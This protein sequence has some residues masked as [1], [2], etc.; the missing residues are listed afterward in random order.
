MGIL[1]EEGAEDRRLGGSLGLRVVE[2]VDESRE[3]EHVGEEDELLPAKRR[4]ASVESG[5]SS[6]GHR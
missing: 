4:P 3:T 2:S 5:V 1:G 6:A